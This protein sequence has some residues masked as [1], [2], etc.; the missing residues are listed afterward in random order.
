M[1]KQ[2]KHIFYKVSYTVLLIVSLFLLRTLV[3]DSSHVVYRI[4]IFYFLAITN[5]IL[6]I[7]TL[8]RFDSEKLYWLLESTDVSIKCPG[9][10][11]ARGNLTTSGET[12]HGQRNYRIKHASSDIAH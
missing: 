10:D 6:Q 2:G 8:E 5:F 9:F 1:R 11:P 3:K 4:I 7:N 12:V